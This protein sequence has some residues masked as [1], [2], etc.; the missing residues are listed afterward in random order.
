MC[1]PCKLQPRFACNFKRCS[2]VSYKHKFTWFYPGPALILRCRIEFSPVLF[3]T[4]RVKSMK[5]VKKNS[6]VGMQ[7]MLQVVLE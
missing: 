7:I 4:L 5:K 2:M 1:T 6:A 3:S